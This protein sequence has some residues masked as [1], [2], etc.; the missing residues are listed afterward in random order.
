MTIPRLSLVPSS[1]FLALQR[2][3]A[4][5]PL[6]KSFVKTTLCGFSLPSGTKFG[7]PTTVRTENR[8]HSQQGVALVL[9]LWVL[10][11][12]TV[13]SASF[14]LSMRRQSEI[15]RNAKD[16]AEAVAIADAGIHYAMFMLAQQELEKR[17]RGDGTVYEIPF[18]QGRVRI[19]LYEEAGKFD[20]NNATDSALRSLIESLDISYDEAASLVDVILD[21]RDGDIFKRPNGAEENDYRDA[22]LSYGPRNRPFQTLEEMQLL[23]GFPPGLYARLE[24]LITVHSGQDGIDPTK[25]SKQALKA[26]PDVNEQIIDNYLEQRSQSALNNLPAP[27]FPAQVEGAV[28]GGDTGSTYSVRAES[29]LLNGGKAAVNAVIQRGAKNI[30]PFGF[31]EWK[32]SFAEEDS[33]FEIADVVGVPDIQ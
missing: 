18:G 26:L 12:L 10:V 24:P 25:S 9:V 5:R 3:T 27:P 1:S 11:L 13:M 22:G 21:W 14:S 33:L 4:C 29:L 6:R 16:R 20:I 17:W 30:S 15:V 7:L 32:R 31:L 19:Q 8:L 2:Q 23:L 28:V